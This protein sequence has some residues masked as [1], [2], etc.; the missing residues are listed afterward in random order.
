[1]PNQLGKLFRVMARTYNR[2]L[3]PFDISSVQAHILATLWIEGQLTIGELQARL[4]LGSST[5]TGAVDRMERAGLLERRPVEGDRRAFRLIPVTWGHRKAEALMETLAKTEDE[6]FRGLTAAER[7][8][9]ASLL[10]KALAPH[11]GDD[12][13]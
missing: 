11:S 1:V 2:A 12:G 10:D 3:V 5:L 6:V 9:L 7:R 8:T 13:E 4:M